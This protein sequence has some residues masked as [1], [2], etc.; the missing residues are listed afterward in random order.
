MLEQPEFH[1]IPNPISLCKSIFKMP[2]AS[3]DNKAAESKPLVNR[4]DEVLD[5]GGRA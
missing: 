5:V 2:E 1:S 3:N 4:A